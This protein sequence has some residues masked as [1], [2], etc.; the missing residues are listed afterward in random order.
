MQWVGG[1]FVVGYAANDAE[2]QLF[3]TETERVARFRNEVG[4]S[5][6]SG[7]IDPLG[8]YFVST[9][10]D[11]HLSIFTIPNPEEESRIG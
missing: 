5:A 3:D 4:A 11:G 7:A 6:K 8:K 9:A 2:V 1:R 10:C